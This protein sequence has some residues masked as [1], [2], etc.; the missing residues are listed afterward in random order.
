MLQSWVAAS[1]ALASTTHPLTMYRG[2]AGRVVPI[3]SVT[4]L[5]GTR[6]RSY[7]E[8]FLFRCLCGWPK[9]AEQETLRGV[10]G[11]RIDFELSTNT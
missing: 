7:V 11:I 5:I 6:T 1:G 10:L 9:I 2:A 8:G 4:R 3:S